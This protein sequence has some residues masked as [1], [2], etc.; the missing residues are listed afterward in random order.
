MVAKQEQ[1][2]NGDIQE[3]SA[4]KGLLLTDRP[5]SAMTTSRPVRAVPQ[6]SLFV[7]QT[8]E[9]RGDERSWLLS[10]P[11]EGYARESSN[12]DP[13]GSAHGEIS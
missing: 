4:N 11:D 6:Q 13:A 12:E 1:T 8:V 10:T 2:A 7:G 9:L 5:I 3:S